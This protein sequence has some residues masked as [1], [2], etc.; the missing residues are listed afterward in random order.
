MTSDSLVELVDLYQTIMDA[1]NLNTVE[2]C[3]KI[4]PNKVNSCSDGKSL[5][6]LL[7]NTN[8]DELEVGIKTLLVRSSHLKFRVLLN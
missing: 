6:P 1:A 8:S 4:D 3:P 5:V 7:T 2:K